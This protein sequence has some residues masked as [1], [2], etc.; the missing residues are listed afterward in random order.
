MYRVVWAPSARRQLEN[1]IPGSVGAAIWEFVNG[2][3]AA[4]PFRV[5]KALRYELE[6]YRSA[7][8][9]EYRIVYRVADNVVQIIR[10]DH[11]RNVYHNPD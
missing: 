11:R 8:R 3:L 5:G 10:V 2:P 4:E 6:G 7:R 1:R 9:G